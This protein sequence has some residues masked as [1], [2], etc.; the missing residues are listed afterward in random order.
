M[1]IADAVDTFTRGDR[2]VTTQWAT[3]GWFDALEGRFYNALLFD[4]ADTILDSGNTADVRAWM[5]A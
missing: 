4:A 3:R 1:L 5:Q 2:K